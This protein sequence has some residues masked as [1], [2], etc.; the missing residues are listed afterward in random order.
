MLPV[1]DACRG[2]G[3]MSF[4]ES[5]NKE[6]CLL[7]SKKSFDLSTPSNPQISSELLLTII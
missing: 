4:A 5:Y 7:T 2:Q 3:A 1:D 6:N